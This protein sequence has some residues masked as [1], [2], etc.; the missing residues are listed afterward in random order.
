MCVF[1]V[2]EVGRVLPCFLSVFFFQK[3]DWFSAVFGLEDAYMYKALA[4]YLEV[5]GDYSPVQVS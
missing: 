3:H 1:N 2:G 5:N 4:S